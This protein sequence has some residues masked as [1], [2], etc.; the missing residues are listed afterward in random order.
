MRTTDKYTTEL[1][2][3]TGMINETLVLLPFYKVGMSK[4]QMLELILNEGALPSFTTIRT[5]HILD[6]VFFNRFVK[7]NSSVPIWLSLIRSKGLLLTDFSQILM[8]YC[9]RVHRIF[10]DFIIDVLNPLKKV[11]NQK[12]RRDLADIYI[13]RI[14]DNGLAQWSDKMQTKNATYIRNTLVAFDLINSKLDIQ[15]YRVSD[16]TILYLMHELH[17]SGL[18]DEAIVNDSDW[19]LLGLYKEDVIKRIMDLNI[20]G[21]YIAQRCGDFITI[22]WKHKTMEE[23]INATL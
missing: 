11:N 4:N 15:P 2:Q 6:K 17:F 7:K 8:V 18:S 21:G 3:G 16:F 20:K 5:E 19:Q 14:V 9:A 12:I 10:Y 22:S 23:F 1:S 13:K